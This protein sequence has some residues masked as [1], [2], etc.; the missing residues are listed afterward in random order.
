MK[1]GCLHGLASQHKRLG[2]AL[3]TVLYRPGWGGVIRMR[4]AM[5]Q[6]TM[7]VG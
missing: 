7:P 1:W 5:L 6:A 3:G 4:N 2:V